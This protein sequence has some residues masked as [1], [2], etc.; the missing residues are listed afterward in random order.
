MSS[1]CEKE[2]PDGPT[3]CEGIASAT[4]TGAV[5]GTYCFTEVTS[6]KYE[7]NNYVSMFTSQDGEIGFDFR[8][9]SVNDAALVAGTY[10]CGQNQPGFVELIIEGSG[11]GEFYKSKSGTLTFTQIDEVNCKG[12]FNVVAEGYYNGETINFSGAFDK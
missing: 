9:N 7:P 2:D 6:Y 8:L 5:D 1:S 10:N 4:S 12:S 11:G 3:S